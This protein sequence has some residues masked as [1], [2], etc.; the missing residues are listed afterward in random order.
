MSTSTSAPARTP[1]RSSSGGSVPGTLSRYLAALRALVVLTVIT[2]LAYPLLI[3]LIGQVAL[4]GR[5]DG[6]LIEQKGTVVGSSLIGQSFTDADG[7][8]LPQWF[9][10]RPTA[11]PASPYDGAASGASNLG[12]NDEAL[13]KT[14]HDRRARVAAENGVAPSAVPPDAL[15]SGLEPYISPPTP[16]SRWP[17]SRGPG[18]WTPRRSGRW[19]PTTPRAV[20]SASSDRPGWTWSTSTPP[21]R[22]W[23]AD[24]PGRWTCGGAQRETS[25]SC[26]G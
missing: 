17:A 24:Q 11:Y 26:A 9:Q 3:T 8:A 19:S 15:G 18:A 4:P 13:R 10:T 25:N 16:T 1:A 21:S 6:Q 20:S 2:G 22:A 12:P 7:A 5:A 14:V 23:P